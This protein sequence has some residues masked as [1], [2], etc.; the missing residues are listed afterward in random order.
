MKAEKAKFWVERIF[1]LARGKS[2]QG[3][4][5]ALRSVCKT[6]EVFLSAL[7]MAPKDRFQALKFAMAD[8]RNKI[9]MGD[10]RAAKKKPYGKKPIQLELFAI[11][12]PVKKQRKKREKKLNKTTPTST[13]TNFREPV[14]IDW[15]VRFKQPCYT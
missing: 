12:A 15:L 3:D 7:S 11:E 14:Q 8:K 10:I 9:K 13:A 5:W 2:Y 4:Y 6:D 1:R